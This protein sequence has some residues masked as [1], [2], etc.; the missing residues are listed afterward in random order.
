MTGA[1]GNNPEVWGKLLDLVD[2]KLQLGLL[3]KLRRVTSYHI[4]DRTLF[5]EAGSADD[6]KYLTKAGN[7]QQLALLAQDAIN[8]KEV[9]IKEQPSAS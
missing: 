2:E 4:E 1:K 8:V 9:V 7:V 5:I 3:D 6:H